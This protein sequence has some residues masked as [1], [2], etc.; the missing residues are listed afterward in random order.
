MV[1]L[2]WSPLRVQ[3]VAVAGV[4]CLGGG[5]L[6][7]LPWLLLLSLAAVLLGVRAEVLAAAGLPGVLMVL[8]WLLGVA[9]GLVVRVGEGAEGRLAAAGPPGVLKVLLWLLG[10]AGGLVVR[11]EEVGE[12][13]LAAAA[14]GARTHGP[15]AWTHALG[16]AP[17]PRVLALAA[18][19]GRT[20]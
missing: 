6:G 9:G 15:M 12:G 18:G 10:V 1:P 4:C 11:V 8:L 20:V 2:R 5:G 16:P 19:H 3:A 17:A 7:G 13:R 14:A